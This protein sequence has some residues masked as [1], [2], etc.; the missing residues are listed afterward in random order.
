M[1]GT[2]E[3]GT[4]IRSLRLARGISQEE[5][6]HHLRLSQGYYSRLEREPSKCT[7]KK[8]LEI[9]AYLEREVKFS[10]EKINHP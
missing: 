3:L 9:M 6:A 1:A 10:F 2:K 8:L 4:K 5:M 7:I